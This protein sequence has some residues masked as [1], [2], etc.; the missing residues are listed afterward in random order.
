MPNHSPEHLARMTGQSAA[1]RRADKLARLIASSPP[2]S[3]AEGRRL[4][5]LLET[6]LVP[7]GTK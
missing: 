5:S 6:R 3:E 1:K 2:L 7:D 4:Q